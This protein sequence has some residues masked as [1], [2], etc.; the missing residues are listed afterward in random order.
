MAPAG[1]ELPTRLLCS[2]K[3]VGAGV[4]V[5]VDER[6]VAFVGAGKVWKRPVKFG[7][8]MRERISFRQSSV[9]NL[10]VLRD[11]V[12]REGLMVPHEEA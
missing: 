2:S 4:V 10:V 9:V 5:V 8:V 7:C 12:R 11:G 3:G 6:R 1:Y